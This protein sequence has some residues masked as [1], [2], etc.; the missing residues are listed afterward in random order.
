MPPFDPGLL[1]TAIHGPMRLGVVTALFVDGPLDFT[2]LK[3]RLRVADGALGLHLQKLEAA[4]YVDCSRAFIGRR[5][6]STYRLTP[7]GRKAFAAYLDQ[8][9]ALLDTARGLDDP[10]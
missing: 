4:A 9:Q 8:M 7:K 3:K 5:P 6:R 1:D 2:T 10:C